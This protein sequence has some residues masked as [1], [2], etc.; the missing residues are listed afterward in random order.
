LISTLVIALVVALMPSASPGG[1]SQNAVQTRSPHGE[2]NIPCQNC[3]SS[4]SWKPIRANPEFDHNKTSY[5][6]RGMHVGVACTQCHTKPVFTN[7]GTKCA[8]CHADIHRGQMGARCEQCHSV[9]GWKVSVQ[10]I[11]NHQN[12]FPLLGAHATVECDAC[13]KGAA[14]GQFQGLSTQCYSCHSKSYQQVTNPNHVTARF[15]TNC[16]E[17]HSMNTWLDAKFDHSTTG[18]PLTGAHMTAPCTS[19]HINGNYNLT[20]ADAACVSCHLKDFQGTTNPNHVS[21]GFPQT[22]QQCHNTSSW[23][24]ATFD[25]N[26]TGFPL[27]GA[28]A[29][30]ACESCHVNGNYNLTNTACVSCH[31]KDF[32]GTTNP[33]HVSGGFPQTCQQCHSTTNWTGATF[34]HSS[35]GFALTG[36]HATTPCANC[37]V[38]GNYNL[39]NTTCVS[40]HLKDFQG[41]TNP[42]HAQQGIAQTCETCHNTAAW[43]PA[44]F[45]HSKSGFPLTGAHATVQCAQCHINNN[46]NITDTTCVS[47]HLKDFQGTTNPNHAQQGFSQTCETC[48]NTAAWQPAQFDHAKSGFPLTGAHAT[49]QC[50]QCHVNN[51]YNITDTTCV[52]CHLKDFQG[53]TDPN[54]VQA[55]FPQTCQQCHNTTDWG[56]ATFDHASTGWALTGA[57][58]TVACTQCHVNGN[59]SLTT[60][61]TNC[62]S[63]HLKDYQGTTNPNHVQSGFPQTCQQCHNTTDWLNA[64]FDHA[65]TGWPLTGVHLTTPCAQCHVNGNYNLTNTAC[66]SCHLQDFQGTTNP[67]HVQSG[68]PQTCQQCHNTTDWLNATFDH[69]STGWPLTGTHL[70]TPCAQCHVNNNYNLTNTACVSCH[71]KDFQGTTNPNHVQAGLPQTCQQCHNTTDWGNGTFDH[72]TTGWALTGFHATVPCAQCHVNGNYALTAANTKCDSC[73]MT[74]YQNTNNPG[75]AAA[76][77][78]TDCSVC[79]NTT[80]WLGATFNHASTGWALTGFHATVQCNQCHVNNNYSLTS[81][82]CVTCHLKDFQSAT[83]PNHVTSGFPQ[84][85]D[86]C[87]NTTAWIPSSFD[88]NATAFPLT[89]AHISVPCASCHVNNNYTTVP[90]DC[91][92]CH[93]TDYTATTNPNHTAAGFPTTCATCHN[94][95]DWMQATFNHTYFPMNHGNANGVCSTCHTNPNDYTVFTCTNCH[96]KTSTDADHRGVNGYVY[97]SINCYNCHRNGRGG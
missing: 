90:T 49:L 34:D 9:Q 15:S 75:H 5:P 58:A 35:T 7:V 14:T 93:K 86:V 30:T 95:T 74:D 19:C 31:L 64:T 56:S 91:Y 73:H 71:L 2:L 88:H 26:A 51:N 60:A 37:H 53:T 47:C 84:V 81:T 85:C 23:A 22:C 8:D 32:Q 79:H 33:N 21:G 72:A 13:H 83:S 10:A 92:S 12:R 24:G 68:F 42:N 44:Q 66:V 17:C 29:T 59:Y 1:Q 39:T 36:A 43:Q 62:V 76:G 61:D 27:T 82:A 6:L 41:T 97:N 38:N 63:C 11:Q 67:N 18:F 46:Y 20:A 16:Q 4:L 40:C 54:H 50:A 45:D 52:S 70:T 28:H 94:T 89:G 78:P 69:A 96:S 65:S 3:H 80:S 55:N 87:H 57:H 48:H 77:F 25:H